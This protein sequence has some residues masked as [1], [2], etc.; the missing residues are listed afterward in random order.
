MKKLFIEAR[1][2]KYVVLPDCKLLPK[3]IALFTTVQ[4]LN[5]LPAMKKQLTE[6]GKTVKL[7]KGKHAAY[8]GQILGCS[9]EKVADVDAFLFVG[10]GFFHPIALAIK[11]NKPVFTFQ[12]GSKSIKKLDS[13]L[14][15]KAKKQLDIAKKKFLMAEK[16][17]IIV[18]TKPGQ[19]RLK[20]ALEFQKKTDKSSVILL[21]DDI[22]FA[23]LEDFSFVEC[24]VNSTC[25]R[26]TFDDYE[27]FPAP[28]LVL[29]DAISLTVK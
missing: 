21:F 18:T 9:T 2:Q 3:R 23:G 22:G 10:D 16:I 14:V 29:E 7:K 5:S 6:Q 24:F 13:I 25:P 28:V 11:N 17:G 20:A 12:P 27:R 1:Y 26:I 4:Y 15:N 19:N 8:A